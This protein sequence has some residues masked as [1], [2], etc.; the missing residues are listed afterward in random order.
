MTDSGSSPFADLF[1]FLSDLSQKKT[2]LPSVSMFSSLSNEHD[3]YDITLCL[4]LWKV[5]SDLNQPVPN[6]LAI[7]M[8]RPMFLRKKKLRHLNTFVRKIQDTAIGSSLH[9]RETIVHGHS[10]TASADWVIGFLL[11]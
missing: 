3:Q 1:Q 9:Q 2:L 11:L 7:K 6:H 4:L 10:K 5:L 8:E